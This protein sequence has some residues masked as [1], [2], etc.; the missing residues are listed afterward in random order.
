MSPDEVRIHFTALGEGETI[1]FVHGFGGA[2]VDWTSTMAAL[3]TEYRAM[4]V[5]WRGHGR[6]DADPRRVA[7]SVDRFVEDVLAALDTTGAETFHL[8]G[9]SIGGGIAQEI[10]VRHPSRVRSLVLADTSDWFGDHD[11]PG[12]RPP[13]LSAEMLAHAARA[14]AMR[15]EVR[16]AAWRA[17]ID[18]QGVRDRLITIPCPTTVLLGERD[19]SR[20]LEGSA[21]LAAAIGG[22]ARV[23]LP[24][25]GHSPHLEAPDAFNRA[26]RAHLESAAIGAT[27]QA[28]ST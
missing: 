23:V 2:A 17:L 11:E 6:S 24:R 1:C 4:A 21:R 20:I 25:V 19:A 22:A 28:K 26:L 5:D 10:A 7:F 8:V 3:E 18:W 15:R 16:E 27:G 13:Y 9:H 14:K 12:G